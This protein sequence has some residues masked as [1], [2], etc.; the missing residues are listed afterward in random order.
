MDGGGGVDLW[1]SNYIAFD[2]FILATIKSIVR[3]MGNIIFVLNLLLVNVS[4]VIVK[5]VESTKDMKVFTKSVFW[6]DG[7]A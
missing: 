4:I 2:K 7:G 5:L 1:N 3:F 6:M